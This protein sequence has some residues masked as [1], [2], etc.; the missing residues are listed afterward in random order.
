M[1]EKRLFFCFRN[2]PF[3][4]SLISQRVTERR[5]DASTSSGWGLQSSR[6]H[7]RPKNTLFCFTRGSVGTF[8][9]LS[10]GGHH[11]NI[12]PS[13]HPLPPLILQAI[14]RIPSPTPPPPP[15]SAACSRVFSARWFPSLGTTLIIESLVRRLEGKKTQSDLKAL[16]C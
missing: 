9:G 6:S 3:Q 10:A 13:C 8:R 15:A 5:R 14:E 2:G 4:L 16:G 11:A 1:T 7:R 12:S